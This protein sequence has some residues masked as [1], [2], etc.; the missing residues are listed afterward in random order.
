MY[1]HENY[2]KRICA[3]SEFQGLKYHG[4]PLS[5]CLCKEKGVLHCVSFIMKEDDQTVS[6]ESNASEVVIK[7]EICLK[8]Q[9]VNQLLLLQ[10]V[11]VLHYV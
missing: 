11:R 6:D 5:D 7:C 1:I 2:L 8:K 9:D 3:E 4:G 10:T